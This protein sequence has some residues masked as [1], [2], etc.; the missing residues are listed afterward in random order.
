LSEGRLLEA[1][2]EAARLARRERRRLLEQT[3]H[4]DPWERYRALNDAMDESYEL[5]DIANREARFALIIMGALNAALLVVSTRSET[6]AAIPAPARPVMAAL[7]AVYAAVAVYFFL[8]AIETLRPRKFRP[9]LR[10]PLG[11]S[12][13]TH[14]L[15]VRYFEDVVERD[16][17][18]HYRAWEEVRLSQLNAELA[19]QGHSLSLKNKAKHDALRRLYA[20]LRVMTLLVALLLS[21][22]AF[23]ALTARS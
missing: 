22:L 7:L 5:I 10:K 17:E 3:R 19:V 11:G 9:R 4:L 21:A 20:G 23:F 2:D 6:V 16:A 18:A 12:P 13:A 8:Q 1:E 14:P 15:G